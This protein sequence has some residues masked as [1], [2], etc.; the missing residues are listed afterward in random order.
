[1]EACSGGYLSTARMLLEH[2]AP[3]AQSSVHGDTALMR[4]CMR[5]DV[6]LVKLLCS[7]GARRDAVDRHGNTAVDAARTFA[8]RP[9]PAD[10]QPRQQRDSS[11][12]QFSH[13]APAVLENDCGT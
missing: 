1:M 4:A 2:G 12:K 5:G 7:Y 10:K 9:E 3:A 8:Q 6:A 13:G 11:N